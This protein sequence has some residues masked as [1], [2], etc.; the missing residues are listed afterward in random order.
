[1]LAAID[2]ND[3]FGLMA[4]EVCEVSTNGRL[5]P[6]VMLLER[7]LPQMLPQLLFSF[8]RVTTQ[9]PSARH[10]AVNRTLRSFRHLPPPTPNP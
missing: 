6:K 2:L 3:Y 8:G 1:M 7:R 4:G 9:G 10:A 5:A